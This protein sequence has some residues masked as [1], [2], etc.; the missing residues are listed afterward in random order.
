VVVLALAHPRQTG[1]GC[2]R[3]RV[4]PAM[5]VDYGDRA[6]PNHISSARRSAFAL[7]YGT[8]E[9]TAVLRVLVFPG[10]NE[11]S[12]VSITSPG[13]CVLGGTGCALTSHTP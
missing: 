13:Y 9:A 5:I 8:T 6:D 2:D 11:R 12:G 1:R 10:G 3:R 4:E 7:K